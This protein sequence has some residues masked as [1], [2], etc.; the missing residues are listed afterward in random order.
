MLRLA[1]LTGFEGTAVKWAEEYRRLCTD[2]SRDPAAGVDIVLLEKLLNDSNDEG[3]HYTIDEELQSICK[4]LESGDKSGL[5]AL[6]SARA[7]AELASGVSKAATPA[8]QLA[9]RLQTPKVPG[10]PF[11]SF[12]ANMPK[13][14]KPVPRTMS[15]LSGPFSKAGGFP[16][17]GPRAAGGGLPRVVPPR[18]VPPPAMPP[19]GRISV[20]GLHVAMPMEVDEASAPAPEGSSPK[21]LAGGA[22][23]GASGKLPATQFSKSAGAPPLLAGGTGS[24]GVLATGASHAHPQDLPK[25]GA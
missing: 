10:L 5:E 4:K 19:P 22:P 2:N 9:A 16:L 1:V 8:G 24:V 18:V 12:A 17:F 7:A 14:L 15:P 6:M 20:R 21:V 25:I 11:L 23:P 3:E 13:V